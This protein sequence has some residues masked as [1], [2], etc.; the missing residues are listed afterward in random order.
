MNK[1]Q[2]ATKWNEYWNEHESGV[3]FQGLSDFWDFLGEQ[4][5]VEE[6]SNKSG[7]EQQSVYFIWKNGDTEIEVN[8][9]VM[10]K[11]ELSNIKDSIQAIIDIL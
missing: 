9:T 7:S 1:Y 8:K 4:M 2:G 10:I 11:N 5:T 3:D 6:W